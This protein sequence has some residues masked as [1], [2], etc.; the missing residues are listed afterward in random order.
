MCSTSFARVTPSRVREVTRKDRAN[1]YCQI[2]R[3]RNSVPESEITRMSDTSYAVDAILRGDVS[4]LILDEAF[5][6]IYGVGSPWF[7]PRVVLQERMVLRIG[8]GSSFDSVCDLLDDL[9]DAHGASEIVVG[10]ALAKHPRALTRMYQ[11]R[12][13]SALDEPSLIKRR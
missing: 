8:P 9:A 2:E 4:G 6:V 3:A 7:S 12:G 1:I 5:L 10:G 11:R 13:Y